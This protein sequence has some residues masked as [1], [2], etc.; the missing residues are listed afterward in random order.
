MPNPSN[1]TAVLTTFNA[2]NTILR[3]LQSILNQSLEP[4]EIIIIDDE[5][6]DNTLSILYKITAGNEKIK[7][8]KTG[9]NTGP[10]NSRNLG[11]SQ[12]KNEF[13]VFFD[14]D[15]ESKV[16][17][18]ETQLRGLED[19]DLNYVSSEKIYSE[20][21]KHK[22]INDEF[23][24][25]LNAVEV[26]EYLLIGNKHSKFKF[27]IPA[28]TLAVRRSAF[29]L[30][31]GFDKT[32]TRLEDVDLAIRA[33]ELRLEFSFSKDILVLRYHSVALDKSSSNESMNQINLLN[34]YESRLNPTKFKQIRD[35][36]FIRSYY[37]N[38][39]YFKLFFKIVHFIL[40]Y[41]LRK[42]IFLTGI[43]RLKHDKLIKL[44]S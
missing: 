33:T 2:E 43:N 6:T 30:L 20:K 3:A 11:V 36:Y 4:N 17:R 25:Q 12:S 16:S 28:S 21:Y 14:D 24:G 10:A 31:G 34:K 7:I 15:D 23:S 9:V 39:N 44:L 29:D 26:I 5:S 42:Q 41:G 40:K 27:S 13:I 38:K 8:Y 32:L 18:A 1:Y 22:Y 19:S 37:F 35:W